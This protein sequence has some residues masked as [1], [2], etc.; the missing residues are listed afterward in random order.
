[1]MKRIISLAASVMLLLET[2]TICHA[3][4]NISIIVA[5]GEQMPVGTISD[6]SVDC[7]INA[8]RIELL[9]SYDGVNFEVEKNLDFASDLTVQTEYEEYEKQIKAAAYSADGELIAE[10]EPVTVTGMKEKLVKQVWNESFDGAEIIP[11][12]SDPHVIYIARAGSR[13]FN[14]DGNSLQGAFWDGGNID[15]KPCPNYSTVKGDS[16]M[17]KSSSKSDT[18]FNALWSKVDG[19]TAVF[20]MD[21]LFEGYSS[22]RTLMEYKVMNGSSENWLAQGVYLRGRRII[23][24]ASSTVA[25]PNTWYKVTAV[26]DT[27]NGDMTVLINNKFLGRE[28]VGKFDRTVRM[29]IQGGAADGAM[30]IDNYNVRRVTYSKAAEKRFELVMPEITTA[31]IGENIGVSA[32]V[33]GYKDAAGIV[34]YTSEDGVYYTPAAE[35]SFDDTFANIPV[36]CEKQFIK[37]EL[38]SYDGTTLAESDI[39]EINA[40]STIEIE[41]LWNVDFETNGFRIRDAGGSQGMISQVVTKADGDDIRNKYDEL[42]EC[43]RG[44]EKNVMAIESHTDAN[45]KASKCIRLYSP[46]GSSTNQFNKWAAKITK[47]IA[48]FSIDACV[49]NEAQNTSLMKL[50]ITTENGSVDAANVFVRSGRA[51][52]YDNSG[53]MVSSVPYDKDV[54]QN[55]K[56]YVNIG[57]G[58]IRCCIGNTLVGQFTVSEK[59]LKTDMIT[60]GISGTD[61]AEVF[62][63]NFL[64]EEI[65]EKPEIISVMQNESM[66]DNAVDIMLDSAVPTEV[67][68]A[69]KGIDLLVGD[70]KLVLSGY[71]I[72]DDGKTITVTS[73][74]TYPSAIGMRCI[75]EYEEGESI[76]EFVLPPRDLDITDVSFNKMSSG[77]KVTA[78]AVNKTGTEKQIIMVCVSYNK[79]DEIIGTSLVEATIPSSS[80]GMSIVC[81]TTVDDAYV[82][83]FFINGWN[84]GAAIKNAV[85]CSN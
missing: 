62:F 46:D 77:R 19:D 30:W 78:Y 40:K 23:F 42:L 44:S 82:K 18:Q 71:S 24:G 83:V 3:D 6:V 28:N 76:F 8:D 47:N 70:R 80:G 4:E 21:Y 67:K 37:A 56:L 66:S 39:G 17:I 26:I 75:V 50:Q 61:G 10:S 9:R 1:M 57:E 29:S 36:I 31:Y 20:E 81:N 52:F 85:Y 11:D 15:I 68:N 64:V 69:V 22:D 45:G 79:N 65:W 60:A 14:D 51:I 16:V 48:V 12:S 25:V 35:A 27:E 72:A 7:M 55:I 59:I 38:I 2:F 13:V 54:W 53:N 58:A 41:K 49:T 84:E 33:N 32:D 74:H 73:E 5:A 43:H 34:Y 63:D